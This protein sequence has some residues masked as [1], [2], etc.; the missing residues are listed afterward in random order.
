MEVSS[1]FPREVAKAAGELAGRQAV[2]KHTQRATFCKKVKTY[3][4]W[5]HLGE[6]TVPLLLP[7]NLLQNFSIQFFQ[8][9][10]CPLVPWKA[11]FLL[12]IQ[13]LAEPFHSSVDTQKCC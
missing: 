11:G 4:K 2:C 7:L 10:P 12:N 5:D 3:L 8:G 9:S 6:E 13:L 1:Y